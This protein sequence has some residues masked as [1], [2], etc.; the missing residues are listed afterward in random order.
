MADEGASDS[1]GSD[2]IS[3]MI[4]RAKLWLTHWIECRDPAPMGVEFVWRVRRLQRRVQRFS[5]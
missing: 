4:L 2:S 5:L 3:G 1:E